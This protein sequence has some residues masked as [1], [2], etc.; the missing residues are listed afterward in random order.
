MKTRGAQQPAL[1]AP[2]PLGSVKLGKVNPRILETIRRLLTPG[3]QRPI[4]VGRPDGTR[5][6]ELGEM[7]GPKALTQWAA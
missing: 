1:L 4:H 7:T 3:L 6:T 5:G 2:Q